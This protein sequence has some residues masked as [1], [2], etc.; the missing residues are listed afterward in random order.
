MSRYDR[1][2]HKNRFNKFLKVHKLEE[3]YTYCC[4]CEWDRGGIDYCHILPDSKGGDYSIN[5]IVPL[6]PNHHRL[7]DRDLLQDYEAEQITDFIY[8][9]YRKLEIKLLYDI[10]QQ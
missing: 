7:L 4:I 6:C 1:E 3:Y 2:T 8:A 5:N 10:E 9:M